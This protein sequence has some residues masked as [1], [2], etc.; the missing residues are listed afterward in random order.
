MKVI[1]NTSFGGVTEE[2]AKQRF[3]AELIEKVLSGRFV[4]RTHEGPFG[5]YAETLK[6]IEIP[7]TATDIRIVNY[8]GCEGVL[9]VLDGLI[10]YKGTPECGEIFNTEC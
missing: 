2:T 4:G 10:F 8:D 3:D 6:V 5:G 9:Y 7:D 1:I